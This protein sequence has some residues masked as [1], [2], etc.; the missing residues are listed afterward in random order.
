MPA[1][2]R[3]G[4]RRSRRA[5]PPAVAGGVVTRPRA[6][7]LTLV[8]QVL[9]DGRRGWPGSSAASSSSSSTVAPRSPPRSPVTSVATSRPGRRRRDRRR[10]RRRSAVSFAA[11]K[12]DD[13]G[14]A[15]ERRRSWCRRS[16]SVAFAPVSSESRSASASRVV[17]QGRGV[18]AAGLGGGDRPV[19]GR[20]LG[21]ERVDLG[22]A[23]VEVRVLVG[24]L[25]VDVGGLEPDRVDQ[26]ARRPA[27]TWLRAASLPGA[28]PASCE[29][30][31]ELAR[32]RSAT[33]LSP[34]SAS[35]VSTRASDA[36]FTSR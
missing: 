25:V 33:P 34:G 8:G 35:P 13:E 6:A 5:S 22:D 16:C 3:P 11:S 12:P 2:R 32:A 15:V 28:L 10:G 31:A 7:A 9:G 4:C 30:G 27:S 18:D 23:D 21:G 29:R 14:L 24:D 1:G 19:G 36:A 17:H 26:R 20:Q